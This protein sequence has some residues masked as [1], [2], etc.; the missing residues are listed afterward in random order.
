MP[1]IEARGLLQPVHGPRPFG[2]TLNGYV[3][4]L[5]QGGFIQVNRDIARGFGLDAAVLIGELCSR[6]YQHADEQGWFW[7]TYDQLGDATCL[8]PHRIREAVKALGGIVE[9]EARG[10]PRRNF[11][12]VNAEALGEYFEGALQ[13][14]TRSASR[15]N[16]N[17]KDDGILA[18]ST[19][20]SSRHP[21][22]GKKERVI[23]NDE[24]DDGA[25][26]P[27]PAKRKAPRR[28]GYGEYGHCM[29]TDDELAKL[30]AEFPDWEDRIRRLDEYCEST[31]KA[32]KNGLATIRSWARRDAERD[33]PKTAPKPAD[34]LFA[35]AK[36]YWQNV[37]K[38]RLLDAEHIAAL[39]ANADFMAGL[40]PRDVDYLDQLEAKA[41]GRFF[42][43]EKLF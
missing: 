33:R 30:K 19:D 28:K 4:L 41:Q 6:A 20:E 21:Y 16:V 7:A 24:K 14:K 26:A 36:A 22:I 43:R 12:R 32:Y 18:A 42:V 5:R 29:L 13:S 39:R 1:Y 2:E 3:A 8:S 11:Y 38:H 37:M 34:P 31:G 40:D 27:K 25:S 23:K 15:E 10:L 17:D 9:V 35:E